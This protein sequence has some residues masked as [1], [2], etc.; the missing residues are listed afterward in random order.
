MNRR[1]LLQATLMNANAEDRGGGAAVDRFLARVGGLQVQLR[2]VDLTVISDY[3]FKCEERKYARALA[4]S[5]MLFNQVGH[6]E[7]VRYAS[8]AVWSF[9][10]YRAGL[11]CNVLPAWLCC[12]WPSSVLASSCEWSTPVCTGKADAFFP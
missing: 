2:S 3:F 1:P 10:P 9:I 12:G 11:V 4:Q 6:V 7:W 8:F 5:R